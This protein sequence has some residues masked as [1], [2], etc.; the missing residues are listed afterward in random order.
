[1][2]SPELWRAVGRE[3]RD[4]RERL[5]KKWNHIAKE[6]RPRLDAKTQQDIERGHPGTLETVERYAQALGLS[7]VDVLSA[8]LKDAEQRP[9]TEVAA[10]LRYFEQLD[11]ENRWLV[12]WT[13][14][15][16]LAMQL[17]VPDAA[18]TPVAVPAR[19]PK[20]P[21]TK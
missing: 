12:L 20:K 15:R 11:A 3:L 16:L 2:T 14:R 18:V 21:P 8:V 19:P 7:I 10:V 6:T 13:V 4:A 1:M 17:G 9:T 5:G